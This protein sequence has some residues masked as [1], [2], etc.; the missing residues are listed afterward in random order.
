MG[1][2]AESRSGIEQIRSGGF[3]CGH[4]EHGSIAGRNRVTAIDFVT[5]SHRTEAQPRIPSRIYHEKCFD[6]HYKVGVC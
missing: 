2:R 1:Y 4:L 3:A 6:I 5:V